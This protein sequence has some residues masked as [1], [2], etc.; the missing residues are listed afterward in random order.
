MEIIQIIFSSQNGMKLQI[1]NRENWKI[2]KYVE[3]KQYTVKQSMG[4]NKSQEKLENILRQKRV[5]AECT[6][7]YRLQ[8]KQYQEGSL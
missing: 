8:Q 6:K 2:H 1:K 5:K 4:Q 7:I 3:I